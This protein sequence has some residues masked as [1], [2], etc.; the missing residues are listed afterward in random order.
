MPSDREA[1]GNNR[2]LKHGSD[3]ARR[4]PCD[5]CGTADESSL[6]GPEG[7]DLLLCDECLLSCAESAEVLKRD[8]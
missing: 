3:G 1:V 4:T 2:E 6:I 8:L 5:G 7:T